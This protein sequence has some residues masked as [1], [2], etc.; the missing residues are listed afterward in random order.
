MF[1]NLDK[2][3]VSGFLASISYR[4]N[5]KAA[6][7]V[8]QTPL[9]YACH[10]GHVDIIRMLVESGAPVDSVSR[11]GETPLMRAIKYCRFSCVEYLIRSGANVMAQNKQGT[12]KVLLLVQKCYIYM[13]KKHF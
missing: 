1:T 7:Q 8:N 12:L 10:E 2:M 11:I 3:F 6:D 4:A 9:H 5:V 13:I